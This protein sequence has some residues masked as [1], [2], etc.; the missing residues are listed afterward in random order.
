L[1]IVANYDLNTDFVSK[2]IG[3][4]NMIVFL[5]IVLSI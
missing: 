1:E 4:F 2:L 5:T 3:A